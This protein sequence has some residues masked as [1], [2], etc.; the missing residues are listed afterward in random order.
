M[1]M[2]FERRN[3]GKE[4]FIECVKFKPVNKKENTEEWGLK[5]INLDAQAGESK[6]PLS[7]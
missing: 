1:R 4:L 2:T 3:I 5:S 7:K 6:R